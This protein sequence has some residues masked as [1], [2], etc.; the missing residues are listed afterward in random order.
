MVSKL[1]AL[2]GDKVKLKRP[3]SG[4]NVRGVVVAVGPSRIRIRISDSDEIVSARPA[5][6]T[7]YSLAARKAWQ[8][9]PVRN[10]GRPRGSKVSDRLS[11]TIRVNRDLWK[12][13]TQAEAEGLIGHRTSILNQ[14]IAEGLFRVS[15][16]ARKAS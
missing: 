10:V 16:A 4:S 5:E 15:A 3:A 2:V 7:N 6:I 8:H 11:V 1:A 9:M 12:R 13:F 14:W